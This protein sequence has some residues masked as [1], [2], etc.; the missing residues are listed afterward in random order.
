MNDDYE[1]PPLLYKDLDAEFHFTLDPCP[2]GGVGGLEK[3]WD[4][5]VVFC[6]PPYS[7]I[8]P[9]VD[10]ALKSKGTVVMLLPS[11]TDRQWFHDLYPRA[12]IRWIKG[13]VRFSGMKTN[14]PF[15]VFIAIIR[16]HNHGRS[17]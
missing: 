15:A 1:T 14:P 10:K 3:D 6:N 8:Q 5:E 13:R 17:L 11:R 4:E 9:W 7:N 16:G 2:I 12:E